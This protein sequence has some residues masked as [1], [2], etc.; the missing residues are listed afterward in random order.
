MK[1][2]L[3]AV[4]ALALTLIGVP[5]AEAEN[6]VPL[7][8]DV[9]EIPLAGV[10]DAVLDADHDQFF[11]SSRS[12][13]RVAVTDLTTGDVTRLPYLADAGAMDLDD[14]GA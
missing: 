11:V 6:G 5:G 4:A 9:A 14:S 3:A 2:L 7:A 13:G 10:T 8:T 12:N 1:A